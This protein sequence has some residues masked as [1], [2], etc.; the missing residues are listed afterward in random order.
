MFN[1]H[2]HPLQAHLTASKQR[3]LKCNPHPELNHTILTIPDRQHLQTFIMLHH[4]QMDL[5][6]PSK[7]R[8]EQEWNDHPHHPFRHLPSFPQSQRMS[9][10]YFSTVFKR[11]LP[12]LG[13]LDHSVTLE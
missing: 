4:L 10:I 8:K 5:T 2:L 1:Y 11:P 6:A 7:E 13:P 12:P 3:R 9:W